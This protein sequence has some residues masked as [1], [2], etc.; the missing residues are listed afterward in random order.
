MPEH[1]PEPWKVCDAGD[2]VSHEGDGRNPL[3]WIEAGGRFVAE[4]EYS[5]VDND[6]ANARRIVACVNACYGFAT[7]ELEALTKHGGTLAQWI[8]PQT[9]PLGP[10][11]PSEP[12]QR[13]IEEEIRGISRKESRVQDV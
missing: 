10:P 9:V 4:T 11:I 5:D 3:C 7:E 2:F 1:S 6:E 13:K 8:A 12:Q